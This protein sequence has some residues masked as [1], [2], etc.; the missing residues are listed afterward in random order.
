MSNPTSTNQ[1]A[2]LRTGILVLV[3]SAILLFT[4]LL[5]GPCGVHFG[6]KVKVDYAFAGPVKRGAA[7]RVAGQVVGSVEKVE[8]LAGQDWQAGSEI[9]V[10]VHLNVEERAWPVLTDTARYYVT[11]LGVLGEH[12]VDIEPIPGGTRLKEGQI[13]RSVELARSD[14]LLPGVAGMMELFKDLIDDQR[15]EVVQLV[16]VT[17]KLL[18]RVDVLI[19]NATAE[20]LQQDAQQVLRETRDLL[21]AMHLMVGDGKALK[22]TIVTSS[23]TLSKADA[24]LAQISP[25]EAREL[26]LAGKAGLGEGRVALQESRAA[27]QEGLKSMREMNAVLDDVKQSPLLKAKRQKELAKTFE[28]TFVALERLSVRAD[29]LMLSIEKKEG[30]AGQAFYDDTLV[31][32]LK[33]VL[34]KMRENPASLFFP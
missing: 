21:S 9:M 29:R 27:L 30:A 14:L 6:R 17:S 20:D 2:A 24:L 32:D 33:M 3:S 34:G 11:T 26:Y 12:Y 8:F 22:R 23:K 15:D 18:A 10:R 5:T 13:I 1:G 31:K 7:V 19:G 4:L 28:D 25:V 16:R